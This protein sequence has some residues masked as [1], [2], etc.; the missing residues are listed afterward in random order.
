W[1]RV[2]V[3]SRAICFQ[4][5]LP[6]IESRGSR[7][8]GRH[9]SFYGATF[10]GEANFME[11]TFNYVNFGSATFRGLANFV[12]ATFSPD[13]SFRET[14]VKGHLDFHGGTTFNASFSLSGVIP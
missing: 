6:C 3:P 10:S 11:A 12:E 1:Q 2:H 8:R 13:G 9:A 4:Y 7:E 14:I 5:S